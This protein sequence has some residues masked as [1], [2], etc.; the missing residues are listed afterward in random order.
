[1]GLSKVNYK[2]FICRYLLGYHWLCLSPA[3]GISVVAWT[4]SIIYCNDCWMYYS[5]IAN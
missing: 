4:F 1:M 5:A 3:V 2:G